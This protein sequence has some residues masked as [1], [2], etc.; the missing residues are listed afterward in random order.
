MR[1]DIVTPERQLVSTD[2]SGVE[3]PGMEGDMTVMENHAPTVT[4]LRPGI[5]RL[6]DGTEFVVSGGF[7]EISD[8]GASVLAEMAVPRAEVNRDLLETWLKEAESAFDLAAEE[9][10]TTAALKV[11]DVAELI[12]QIG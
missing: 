9:A 5:V 3:I 2:A 4:T 7:A 6:E 8:S 10:K 1:V 11:N 12:R